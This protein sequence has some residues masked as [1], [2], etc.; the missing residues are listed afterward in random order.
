MRLREDR[1]DDAIRV[2]DYDDNWPLRFRTLEARLRSLLGAQVVRRWC[3]SSTSAAPPFPGWQQSQSWT[4]MSWCELR[5]ICS[6]ASGNWRR[7]D[8]CTRGT[9]AFATRHARLLTP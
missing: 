5:P 7:P 2:V 3:A 4:S 1:E 8:T 9:W 6:R